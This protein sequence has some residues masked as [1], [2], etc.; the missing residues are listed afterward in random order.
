M[1]PLPNGHQNYFPRDLTVSFNGAAS[2]NTWVG[3]NKLK[4]IISLTTM[5]FSTLRWNG[6]PRKGAKEAREGDPGTKRRTTPP[7]PLDVKMTIAL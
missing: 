6:R 2:K 1:S 4:L 3:K 5:S 7:R